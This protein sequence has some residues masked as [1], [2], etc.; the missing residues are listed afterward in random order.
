MPRRILSTDVGGDMQLISSFTVGGPNLRR[1]SSIAVFYLTNSYSPDFVQ[2]QILHGYSFCWTPM[3]LEWYWTKKRICI[4]FALCKYVA[5]MSFA[6]L[7]TQCK[8]GDGRICPFLCEFG[9]RHLC[10]GCKALRIS[11]LQHICTRQ[12]WS[13]FDFSSSGRSMTLSQELAL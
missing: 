5:S 11:Y 12:I 3:K 6:Q 8:C 13:K 1:S 4:K 2:P 9:H 7:C 10:T